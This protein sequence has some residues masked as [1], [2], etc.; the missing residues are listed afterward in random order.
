[1]GEVWM[2]R[3]GARLLVVPMVLLVF[4]TLGVGSAGAHGGEDTDEASVLVRQAI[5]LIVSSPEEPGEVQER[6]QAAAQAADVSGVDVALVEEAD[7]ALTS[8]DDVAQVRALLER[9]IGAGPVGGATD[10]TTQ[11]EPATRGDDATATEP[12]AAEEGTDDSSM[13]DVATGA[14]PGST[15]LTDS[16]E[17]RPELGVA[18]WLLIAGSILVGLVGV[19]VALRFRPARSNEATAR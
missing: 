8:G 6:V 4:M 3:L 15:V 17:T 2:R 14:D 1:M 10:P 12:T 5:A 13:A 11:N 9:S 16:L 7:A 18:D 19:W